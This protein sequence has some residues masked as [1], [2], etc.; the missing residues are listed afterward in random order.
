V[1][2][3][4]THVKHPSA[5]GSGDHNNF[6]PL[7]GAAASCAGG[8]DEIRKWMENIQNNAVPDEDVEESTG[9]GYAVADDNADPAYKYTAEANDERGARVRRDLRPMENPNK[10][11]SCSLYI[12][13][14]PLF[15]RHIRDQ[16]RFVLLRVAESDRREIAML[17]NPPRVKS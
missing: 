6:K 13:T 10:K 1:I 12:Q 15:W 5:T 8:N 17:M 3:H 11:K 2:Y 4:E 7:S 14:D 9:N 16:V